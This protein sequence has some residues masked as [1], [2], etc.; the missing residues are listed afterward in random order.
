MA[1]LYI[2]GPI[3]SVL[4][5]MN[6]LKLGE[7]SLNKI[8]EIYSGGEVLNTK[9]HEIDKCWNSIKLKNVEYCYGEEGRKFKVSVENL[10]FQKGEGLFHC[11]W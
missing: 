8:N 3:A 1:L 6:Q 9:C 2:T 5:L 7:I 11:W 4:S 10:E